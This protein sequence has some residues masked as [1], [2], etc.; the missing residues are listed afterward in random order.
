V[1][2]LNINLP[3]H[4]YWFVRAEFLYN[5]EEKHGEYLECIVFGMASLPGRAPL[6]HL[7]TR[8]GACFWRV[9]LHAL[10]TK[11]GAPP[12]ELWELCR[13]DCFG[14]EVA[15]TEFDYLSEARAEALI[16]TECGELVREPG[17]YLFTFDWLDNGFSNEPSQHKCGHIIALDDGNLACLPNNRC[18]FRDASWTDPTLPIPGY[19]TNTHSWSTEQQQVRAVQDDGTF[20]YQEKHE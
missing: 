8:D 17:R 10:C 5:L 13:W 9:P 19:R 18:L 11:E 16:P 7:L 3:E 6:F 15:V 12:R 2:L 1:A 14:S 4:Q 20:F